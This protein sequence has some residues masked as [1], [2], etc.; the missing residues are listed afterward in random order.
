MPQRK[1]LG[2]ISGNAQLKTAHRELSPATRGYIIGAMD[3]GQSRA[4]VARPKADT[5]RKTYRM[6]K[7]R[8]HQLSSLV[9]GA[10]RN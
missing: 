8:P 5:V 4:E 7:E 6:R 1:I 9:L 2:E 3:A 10:R